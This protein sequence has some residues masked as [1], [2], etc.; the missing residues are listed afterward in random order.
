[1]SRFWNCC[2]AR[3]SAEPDQ[4]KDRVLGDKALETDFNMKMMA[5]T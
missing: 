1:M 4:E 2:T 5:V 3:G